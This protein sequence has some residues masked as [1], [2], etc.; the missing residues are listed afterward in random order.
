M[1]ERDSKSSCTP[2]KNPTEARA[3]Q[4]H[5]SSHYRRWKRISRDI[6]RLYETSRTASWHPAPEESLVNEHHHTSVLRKT[7]GIADTHKQELI[8]DGE[9]RT[10]AAALQRHGNSLSLLMRVPKNGLR[11]DPFRSL[12]IPADGCVPLTIDYFLHEWAPEYDIDYASTG[13]GCP[14]KSLV[15]PLAMD[16]AVLLE[17]LVA[18]CRVFWLIARDI[19]W[20]TDAEYIKH[21]GRALALV[22]AKLS[23]E[24]F[25]DN[26]TLL[27]I[28]CL[29]SIEVRYPRS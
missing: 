19:T 26:A 15:F 18:M 13:H 11:H 10:L 7:P 24:A 9:E 5:I 21:Q 29:T 6:A 25:A 22:Q 20:H 17:S 16:H 4:S 23:S 2:L 12:P 8:D 1:A 14:H 3:F 28:V 27:A